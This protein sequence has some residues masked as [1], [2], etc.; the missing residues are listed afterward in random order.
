MISRNLILDGIT[1]PHIRISAPDFQI[2]RSIFEMSFFFIIFAQNNTLMKYQDLNDEAVVVETAV[3]N[4]FGVDI[5]EVRGKNRESAVVKSR[6]F[7]VYFLHS[8]YGFSGGELGCLYGMSRHWVFDICR[9]MKDYARIDA[10]YRKEMNDI[11]SIL[12]SLT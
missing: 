12:S 7:S 10:K 4:Y 9:Q 2:L 3:A 1:V 8:K 5:D 6:H 11:E